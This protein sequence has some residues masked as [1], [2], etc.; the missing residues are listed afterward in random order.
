MNITVTPFETESKEKHSLPRDSVML[1]QD[2]PTLPQTPEKKEITLSEHGK[3]FF[4]DNLGQRPG[5][6][7][8]ES[9]KFL[10]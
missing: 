4:M 8:R 7:N 10:Q 5:A 1:V 9:S 3:G 6:I 2:E